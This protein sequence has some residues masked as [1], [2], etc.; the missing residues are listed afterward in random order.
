M[1]TTSSFH[2][3]AKAAKTE[4]TGPDRVLFI[5][6]VQTPALGMLPLARALQATFPQ[7]DVV[8]IDLW[9]HGLSDTPVVPHKPALFHGL[10]DTLLNHI[11]WPSAHFV[12]YSFGGSLTAGYAA[13]R[14]S[15][16]D[17]FVIIAPAGLLR[18]ADLSPEEQAHLRDDCN[19]EAAARKW[20]LEWLEGG[21]LIVPGD[22][23]ERVRR[24]EIVAEAVREWQMREHS[25]HVASVIAIVRDGGVMDAHAKF[26]KAAQTGIPAFAVL[27][28]MDGVC[29]EQLL[30][31]QGFNNV[32]IVPQVGHG[33]VR[34]RVPEVA[35]LISGFWSRLGNQNEQQSAS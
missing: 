23:K 20:V 8:L 34:E 16:V 29:S 25:G 7:T 24:G 17:S 1:P 31:E 30:N 21:E 6:G 9:G 12:G 4:T 33:V 5:H 11:A 19:D 2:P 32:A 35:G 10:L 15:R 28:E 18:A 22:W 26:R 14:P 27:G 13:R 3:I